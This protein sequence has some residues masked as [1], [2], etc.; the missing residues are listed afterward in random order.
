MLLSERLLGSHWRLQ[1]MRLF[2][3]ELVWL[4]M[5]VTME[6][7]VMII[8]LC[9]SRISYFLLLFDVRRRAFDA[10]NDRIVCPLELPHGILQGRGALLQ[11]RGTLLEQVSEIGQHPSSLDLSCVLLSFPQ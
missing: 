4:L 7:I 3:L 6:R 11:G 9:A 5:I 8:P 2:S 1:Y 10:Q